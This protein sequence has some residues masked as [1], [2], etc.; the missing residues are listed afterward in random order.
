MMRTFFA[1][2]ALLIPVAFYPGQRPLDIT[3]QRIVDL[4]HAYGPDTVYWPTSP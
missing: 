2:M 4:S 1:C 3:G